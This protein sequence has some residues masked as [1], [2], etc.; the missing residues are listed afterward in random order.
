M[1][2]KGFYRNAKTGLYD[3]DFRVEGHRFRGTTG[4][5][6]R[7]EAE[8]IVREKRRCAEALTA[9]N[10]GTQAMSFGLASSRWYQERG[11]QRARP[12]EVERYLAW[13]QQAIGSRT[14]IASIDG[15]MVARLCAQRQAE[16]V[17]PGTINRTVV[18]PLR[19]IL[20]RAEVWGQKIAR[21]E[22]GNHTLAEPKE[23]VRELT[24]AEEKRLLDAMR[25]DYRPIIRFAILSGMRLAE[26]VA[27]RW[28]HVD[29][30]GR[31]LHLIGKGDV[32][33][34]IPL[35]IEMERALRQ[36]HTP[37]ATGPVWT[38]RPMRR[39]RGEVANLAPK[40]I[41]IE[42]L[43]TQFR[44]ARARANIPSSRADAVMGFRFH[45]QRHTAL[46]RLV[47]QTG[48]LKHAQKLGR[49]ADIRTT[50][51][52]AHVTDDD[53]RAALNATHSRKTSQAVQDQPENVSDI[54]RKEA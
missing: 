44:R 49:H 2:T 20:R 24:E 39:Q 50:M 1:A 17:G 34:T 46:T 41:T 10:A 31:R 36:A 19:A 38:Y 37:D 33:A 5:E 47:R 28:H 42:G 52:Y 16:G 26:L 25:P 32:V 21:V 27:M 14:L 43:K 53:L 30:G 13:L 8:K 9:E 3:Y 35:S 48:N 6:N 29:W 12:A 51:R 54:K 40:P 7:R 18:D 11:Q 45:D 23:R 4:T 15:N 22:W